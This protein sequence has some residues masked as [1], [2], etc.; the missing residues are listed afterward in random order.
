[1]FSSF[2][3]HHT[4]MNSFGCK[5]KIKKE[6]ET[7]KRKGREAKNRGMKCKQMKKF[8]LTERGISKNIN[9]GENKQIKKIR[10]QINIKIK[11]HHKIK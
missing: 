10:K 6:Q 9:F 3:W 11:R 8:Y 2:P 1:M 7:D 4:V 5:D